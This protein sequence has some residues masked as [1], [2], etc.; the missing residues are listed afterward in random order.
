[1]GLSVKTQALKKSWSGKTR[2]WKKSE[3]WQEGCTEPPQVSTHPTKMCGADNHSGL[4]R[5]VSRP[6][7]RGCYV[8]CYV[9]QTTAYK[10]KVMPAAVP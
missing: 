2:A 4:C 3:N 5:T 6:W 9:S 8:D 10:A 7:G 1:M